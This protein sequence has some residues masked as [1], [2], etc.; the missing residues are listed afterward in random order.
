MRSIRGLIREAVGYENDVFGLAQEN[1]QNRIG[2]DDTADSDPDVFRFQSRDK[3]IS[4]FMSWFLERLRE[5]FFEPA[6]IRAVENG[7]HWTG[8]L[9]RLAYAQGW[10]QARNRLRQEG[11]SV[12]SLPGSDDE[13]QGLIMALGTMPAPRRSLETIYR[14][15]YQNLQSIESDMTE[16]VRAELLTGLRDGVN[17]RAMARNLTD[18][19][20]SLQKTRAEML[21]RTET[22]NAYTEATLDRYREAGVS[23]VTQVER[24][25]ASDSRVCPICE[26]LDG[27]ITPMSEIETATFTFEPGEDDQPSLAGEYAV[28]PPS[29]PGCRCAL[30]P[31][32]G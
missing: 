8:E 2:D 7:E 16:V 13:N 18:E 32:I 28:A 20:E 6:D 23:A 1:S 3:N 4:Q 14:R 21:A 5:G 29:H 9:L 26:R 30:K 11:V 31:V 12:G 15:T 27:R 19:I 22:M 25:D 17:P 10:R 24:A